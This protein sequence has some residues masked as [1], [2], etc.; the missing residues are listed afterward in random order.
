MSGF[1]KRLRWLRRKHGMTQEALAMEIGTTYSMVSRYELGE[2]VPT[3]PRL[4]AMADVFGVS[5]DALWRGKRKRKDGGGGAAGP[6][7]GGEKG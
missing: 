3:A 5:M 2:S 7:P 1:G 4:Q 6:A